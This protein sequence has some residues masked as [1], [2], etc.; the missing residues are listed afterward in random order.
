LFCYDLFNNMFTMFLKHFFV[1]VVV[2][3]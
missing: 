1:V 3:F 2:K